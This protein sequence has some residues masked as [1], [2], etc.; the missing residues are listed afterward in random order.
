MNSK[1]S[2][3]D[4]Q[5]DGLELNPSDEYMSTM[6]IWSSKGNTTNHLYVSYE[7]LERIFV[8]LNEDKQ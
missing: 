1:K 2:Y 3:Y 6:K 7:Q 4:Q 8:I 5:F